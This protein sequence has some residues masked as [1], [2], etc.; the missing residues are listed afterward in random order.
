MN[1]SIMISWELLSSLTCASS[2][3]LPT[4]H[5]KETGGS[6]AG[7][8]CTSV[9]IAVASFVVIVLFHINFIYVY[10]RLRCGRRYPNRELDLAGMQVVMMRWRMVN[11]MRGYQ[12]KMV[13]LFSHQLLASLSCV[14]LC[15]KDINLKLHN[16][17][18]GFVDNRKVS[19]VSQSVQFNF[20]NVLELVAS[21]SIVA[22]PN[23]L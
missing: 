5:V 19:S 20:S 1:T 21:P 8:A 7:L 18:M 22:R 15:L 2:Q 10:T 3:R 23:S 14:N 4:I 9:G 12:C 11:R 6:Q 16:N 17:Y 13:R